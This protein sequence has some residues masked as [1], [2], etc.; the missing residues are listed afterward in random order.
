MRSA[1]NS[2][3]TRRTRLSAAHIFCNRRDTVSG[4]ST[5]D[6]RQPLPKRFKRF[7]R[8]LHRHVGWIRQ[9]QPKLLEPSNTQ[10][11]LHPALVQTPVHFRV[12]RLNDERQLQQA[13]HLRLDQTPESDPG[14]VVVREQY[15]IFRLWDREGRPQQFPCELQIFDGCQS[16]RADGL[17]EIEQGA[18][19][20]EI[21]EI[22]GVND[23]DGFRV[24]LAAG[25]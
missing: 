16:L 22:G 25:L 13:R 15:R 24:D 7:I 3:N 18:D 11:R 19:V 6:F 14:G 23:I 4:S 9:L 10:Q 8:K 5:H 2:T 17:R 1:R 20:V 21:E 12:H